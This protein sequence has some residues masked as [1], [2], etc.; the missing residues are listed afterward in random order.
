MSLLKDK[1]SNKEWSI[2]GEILRKECLARERVPQAGR[3]AGRKPARFPRLM[4]N[5]KG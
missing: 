1:V 5:G 3:E 4:C 2:E